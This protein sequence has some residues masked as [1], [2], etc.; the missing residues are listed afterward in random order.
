[1]HQRTD[2]AAG[3]INGSDRLLVELIEPPNKPPIITITWPVKAT[4]CTPAQLDAVVA[5]AMRLLANSTVRLAQLRR[6]RKL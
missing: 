5:A 3:Q 6:D 1:M 4:V 2:L